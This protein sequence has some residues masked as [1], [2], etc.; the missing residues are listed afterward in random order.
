MCLFR[1]FTKEDNREAEAA[2][3]KQ[4]ISFGTDEEPVEFTAGKEETEI[5]KLDASIRS[6]I[7]EIVSENDDEIRSEVSPRFKNDDTEVK[8]GTEI[9]PIPEK[10]IKVIAREVTKTL[11]MRLIQ[12]NGN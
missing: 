10:S 1:G 12:E 11:E 3:I 2:I 4:D 8:S 9:S 5:A 6:L 7:T